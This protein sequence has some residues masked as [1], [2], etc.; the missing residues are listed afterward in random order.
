MKDMLAQLQTLRMQVVEC[1]RL[2]QAAK[3]ERKRAA[4]LRVIAHYRTMIGELEQTISDE[5]SSQSR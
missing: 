1:E 2:A 3:S 5:A 4:F